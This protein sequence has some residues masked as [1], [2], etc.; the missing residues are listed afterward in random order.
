MYTQKGILLGK[1]K[2]PIDYVHPYRGSFIEMKEVGYVH[3]ERESA[4]EE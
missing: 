3:S 1:R 2:A 4:R